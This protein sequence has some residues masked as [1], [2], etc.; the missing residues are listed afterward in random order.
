MKKKRQRAEAGF[1]GTAQAVL[2]LAKRR[3]L[4][5][6]V[7]V[8]ACREVLKMG[9]GDVA[10]AWVKKGWEHS[11]VL[12]HF[13]EDM[14]RLNIGVV[15]KLGGFLDKAGLGHQGIALLV[16]GAPEIDW[17]LIGQE[18][19][20][21]F[22]GL[23]GIEDPHNLGAILRTAW[24]LGVKGAVVPSER[25]VGLTSTVHKVACGGV[26]HVPVDKCTRFS[27]PFEEFK[28]KGFWIYGLSANGGRSIWE[29][30]FSRKTVLVVGSED[31]GLRIT[32]ENQCDELVHIPQACAE[33]SYNASVATA[34]AL[35]EV[36]R[37]QS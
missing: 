7:G 37:Q 18:E 32:T 2:G 14:R 15:E 33:G 30:K 26:E 36:V 3:G 20:E 16:N 28:E 12:T 27:V 4:R 10:E 35:A 9:S 25:S 13:Y 11:D 5:V 29:T 24:L 23:D 19:S 22:L 8:H 1:S 17:S 34:L 31:K 6:V 21:V